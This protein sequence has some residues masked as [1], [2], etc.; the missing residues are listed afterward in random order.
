MKEHIP[1]ISGLVGALIGAGA[2]VITVWL[3]AKQ[4][5]QQQRWARRE[6]HYLNL[7]GSLTELKVSLED[8]CEYFI[9]PGSEYST[10]IAE[11]G[12]F[13]SLVNTGARAFKSLRHQIG[14]AS[15]FLSQGA[16]SA[17]N[18]LVT[19]EWGAGF[20]SVNQK[21]YSERTLQ[22]VIKVHSI[23]LEEARRHLADS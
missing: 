14:P 16:V 19:E 22:I 11:G 4:W 18:E 8:R 9:E 23:I 10:S 15:V 2:A 21:E 7:M 17:L 13:R 12:N 3:Q 20:D 1:L 5:F 6:Q